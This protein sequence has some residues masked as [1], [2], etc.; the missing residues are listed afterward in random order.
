M[1]AAHHG[2][3]ARVQGMDGRLRLATLLCASAI[4]LT[5][6]N[7]QQSGGPLTGTAVALLGCAA[8]ILL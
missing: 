4:T 3:H 6:V 8:T 5:G 1:L 7:M 2:I